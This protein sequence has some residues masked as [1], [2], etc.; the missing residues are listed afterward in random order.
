MTSYSNALPP[1][2]GPGFALFH[3]R[4]RGLLEI[5]G[6]MQLQRRLLHLRFAITLGHIPAARSD[7]RL[8]AERRIFRD[9]LCKLVRGRHELAL[10]R[11]PADDVGGERLLCGE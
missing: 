4:A 8:D 11:D 6:Q 10:R 9:R 3:E 1:L 5:L 2:E 7:D